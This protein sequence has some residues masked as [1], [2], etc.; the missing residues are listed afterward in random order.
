LTQIETELRRTGSDAFFVVRTDEP[1]FSAALS[2]LAYESEDGEFARRFPG[3]ATD[4]DAIFARFEQHVVELLEQTARRRPVLWEAALAEVAARLE[5]HAV[6]WF[7]VGS[8]ALAVRGIDI[9]PRD[10]D[11]VV[12]DHERT[13]MA[14]AD[15][16]IEPPLEDRD[17]GWVAAWFGRAFLGAR[18]E[19]IAG[20]Y[21]EA[22]VESEFGPAAAEPLERVRWRGR[23]LRLSPLD[24]QLDVARRR[25][26]D[27]RVRAIREFRVAGAERES[28]LR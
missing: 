1:G 14:L 15:L 25:G 11:L 8:G 20:V 5:A 23:E 9:E 12:F 13:A 22:A 10:L 6:E 3:D 28:S 17:R 4:L 18:V 21:A 2:E 26:L 16:L 7:L 24:L 27:D 19:W